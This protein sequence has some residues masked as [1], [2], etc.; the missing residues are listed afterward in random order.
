MVSRRR[1]LFANL[2]ISA[3]PTNLRRGLNTSRSDIARFAKDTNDS[4]ASIAKRSAIV[5]TTL[6]AGLIAATRA[7]ALNADQIAKSGRAL[8]FAANEYQKLVFAVEKVGGDLTAIERG[9]LR[10]QK[11]LAG[12]GDQEG[13]RVFERLGLSIERFRQLGP[14]DAFNAVIKR[15]AEVGD[16]TERNALTMSLFGTRGSKAINLLVNDMASFRSELQRAEEIGATFLDRTLKNAQITNDAFGDLGGVITRG[17]ADGAFQQAIERTEDWNRTLQ[18]VGNTMEAV[19]SVSINVFIRSVN[20][21]NRTIGEGLLQT[22]RFL[23]SITDVNNVFL[24]LTTGALTEAPAALTGFNQQ[25][26]VFDTYAESVVKSINAINRE[27]DHLNEQIGASNSP[28]PLYVARIEELGLQKDILTASVKRYLASLDSVNDGQKDASDS[29]LVLTDVVGDYIDALQEEHRIADLIGRQKFVEVG[30]RRAAAKGLTDEEG[31]LRA[32][33]NTRY[34]VVEAQKA[35]VAA[36]AELAK[37]AREQQS[38]LANQAALELEG[39]EHVATQVLNTFETLDQAVDRFNDNQAANAATAAELAGQAA[40]ELA[41]YEQVSTQVLGTFETLEHAAER[42]SRQ[43]RARIAEAA[44]LVRAESK[45]QSD[46]AKQAAQELA[47]YEDVAAQVLSTFE[48]LDQAVERFAAEQEAYAEA[49]ELGFKGTQEELV[50]LERLT[51]QTYAEMT[52]IVDGFY[53]AAINNFE[54]LE[55]E[56]EESTNEIQKI[57]DNMIQNMQRNFAD[58]IH[59][60]LW[61]KGISSF[62]DFGNALLDIW[63]RAISEMVAAWATSGL[64]R[65][66]TGGGGGIGGAIGGGAGGALGLLQGVG[67]LSGGGG[68]ILG[69]LLGSVGPIVSG[70]GAIGGSGFLGGLGASLSSGGFGLFNIGANAGLAGGGIGATIG[71]ALPALAAVAVAVSF[72][73]SKTKLLD[74][75]LRITVDSTD[76]LVESFRRV[77]K[78]RFWGLSKSTRET[79]D[80]VSDE[81]QA[82]FEGVVDQTRQTTRTIFDVFGFV[83][84]AADNFSEQFKISLKGLTDDEAAAAVQ[85]AMEDLSLRMAQAAFEGNGLN[86]SLEQTELAMQQLAATGELVA[87]AAQRA[88][89]IAS[90]QIDTLGAFQRDI[91]NIAT[92]QLGDILVEIQNEF[93]DEIVSRARDRLE[94]LRQA[95]E[96]LEE[97]R[98]VTPELEAEREALLLQVQT[99]IA[100]LLSTVAGRTADTLTE[101]SNSIVNELDNRDQQSIEGALITRILEAA[102]VVVAGINDLA[103][104]AQEATMV[105][106]DFL[107]SNITDVDSVTGELT[108][109]FLNSVQSYVNTVTSAVASVRSAAGSALA[110][111]AAA[112]AAASAAR[113]RLAEESSIPGFATGGVVPGPRGAPMLAVVHGGEEVLTPEQRGDRD[114]SVVVNISIE[115]DADTRVIRV[116]ERRA[117]EVAGILATI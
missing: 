88:N 34:E 32:Y 3:D 56:T 108:S 52:G 47:G 27:I 40:L 39:Y 98:G 20:A 19:G 21:L 11:Q 55:K 41:G 33:L 48:T 77:R 96:R 4:F 116:L 7:A 112:S 64:S 50:E 18:I 95:A 12:V 104:A 13:V 24:D 79:Y 110:E 69:S 37:L 67:A 81:L 117:R 73:S 5:I 76:T 103:V 111:V 70:V 62:Q 60:A 8:G 71:A 61:E 85:M 115:G 28:L 49:V 36:A 75:G 29:T 10:F 45:R 74:E 38:R 51:D 42:F 78:S 107:R 31:R 53:A 59:G 22:D 46:L 6:T 93:G 65:I 114:R 92:E 109:A 14:E 101:L 105:T 113:A 82:A 100:T 99:E 9:I 91:G 2:A 89:L 35:E 57:W 43:Q 83:N 87:L 106:L 15:L 94:S 97:S 17:L 68:G 54:D 16:L 72:F 30:L 25:W 23:E 84:D 58:T 1:D 102:N 90:G 86:L 26:G 63:K 44:E 80:S 66:L